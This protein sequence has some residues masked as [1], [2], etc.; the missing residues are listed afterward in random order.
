MATSCPS[1]SPTTNQRTDKYGGSLKNHARIIIEIAQEIRKKLPSSFILGI[2]IN[3]VEFQDK[4]FDAEE[5][6]QLCA[7]LEENKFD[8]VE[9]SG[10][11]YENLVGVP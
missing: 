5:C 4:G 6:K 11:T 9:L 8:F 10:G 3:S 1:F 2:K 7:S